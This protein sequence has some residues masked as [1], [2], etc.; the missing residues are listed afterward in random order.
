MWFSDSSPSVQAG[1][2]CRPLNGLFLKRLGGKPGSHARQWRWHPEWAK[3]P[4]TFSN[5]WHEC[6]LI[7]NGNQ[8]EHH[9]PTKYKDNKPAQGLGVNSIS[10]DTDAQQH[11]NNTKSQPRLK[12]RL[13]AWIFFFGF[14]DAVEQHHVEVAVKQTLLGLGIATIW[15]GSM[16]S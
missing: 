6:Q 3:N 12:P 7:I 13:K 15:K 9:H 4:K 2:V 14:E 1:K 11:K 10:W 5:V 16:P 8:T